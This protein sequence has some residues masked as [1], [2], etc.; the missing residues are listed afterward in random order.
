[1][2]TVLMAA[3]AGCSTYVNIP[4][5]T[6]DMAGNNPNVDGV[7]EV[8]TVALRAMVERTLITGPFKL[9]LPAGTTAETYAA[10][11]KELGGKAVYDAPPPAAKAAKSAAKPSDA[12]AN[13]AP[14]PAGSP[15]EPDPLLLGDPTELERAAEAA[16]QPTAPLPAIEVRQIRIRGYRAEVDIIRPSDVTEPDSPKVLFTVY[17]KWVPFDGWIFQ[18]AQPWRIPVEDALE[19][20][21]VRTDREGPE[22]PRS[23]P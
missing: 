12:D 16:G 22:D 10:I 4:P 18:R 11:D 5:Q 1:M 2:A 17:E 14:G 8:Q 3:L 9:I 13:D 21:R 7:V 15:A 20:S 6:G 23:E 19:Q